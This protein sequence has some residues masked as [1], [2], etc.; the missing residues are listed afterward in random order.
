MSMADMDHALALYPIADALAFGGGTLM[1]G[2]IPASGKVYIPPG[3]TALLDSVVDL[4]WLRVGGT[5][6]I[7]PAAVSGLNHDTLIT[8]PMVSVLNTGSDA[9]SITG[10]FDINI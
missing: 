9:D 5:L 10:Q 6:N 2:V 4:Q 8:E 3:V 7:A 1:R